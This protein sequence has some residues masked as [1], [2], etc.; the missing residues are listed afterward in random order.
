MHSPPLLSF[1]VIS[2]NYQNYIPITLQSILSQT[3]QDFEIVVVDDCSQDDSIEVIN[4][5]ADPRIRLYSNNVNRGATFSYNRA[6]NLARGDWLVN[7]DSDD[8]ISPDKTERQLLLL[9][10]CPDLDIIGS[11][12]ETVDVYGNKHPNAKELESLFNCNYDLNLLETWIGKNPLCRS[13]TMVRRSAHLRIGLDDPDM[14]RAPDYELW[15]RAL[16]MGCCFGLLREPLTYLR[17]H[18]TSVT[19]GDPVRAFLELSYAT[20][21]NLS[22]LAEERSL[23]ELQL[24]MLAFLA[25][26]PCMTS[27]TQVQSFLLINEF[28]TLRRQSAFIDFLQRLS[29]SSISQEAIRIGRFGLLSGQSYVPSGEHQ[30]LLSDIAEYIEA[31]N[32]WCSQS[33]SWENRFHSISI[34]ANTPNPPFGPQDQVDE[35]Q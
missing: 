17:V 15:T 23:F 2:Y 21:K 9:E 18:S 35:L 10:E 28:L 12:V 14:T 7:L 22:P 4:G 25:K 24:S 29:D 31:V 11:W 20:V 30:K 13:S 6:V 34:A 3:I 33:S 26:H 5:I 27:I 16:A 32:F 19:H 1:V 8:F